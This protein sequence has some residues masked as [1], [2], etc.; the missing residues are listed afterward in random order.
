[1][2][3]GTY[4]TITLSSLYPTITTTP[5]GDTAARI[6]GHAATFHA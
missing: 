5:A 3:H 4:P 1:M 2:A 6:V